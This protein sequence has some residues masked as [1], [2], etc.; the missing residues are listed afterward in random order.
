[1]PSSS[2]P[3]NK[4]KINYRR[5]KMKKRNHGANQTAVSIPIGKQK[6]L[7]SIALLTFSLFLLTFSLSCEQDPSDTGNSNSNE[8]KVSDPH[9]GDKLSVSPAGLGVSFNMRYVPPTGDE[10]FQWEDGTDNIATIS[11]GYWIGE[12][13][14][15]QELFEAVMGH[16]PSFVQHDAAVLDGG[17]LS[18]LFPVETV[19]WYGAITFCNK[20]SILEGR[21]PVYS[22]EGYN[23]TKWKIMTY[24]KIPTVSDE[25][26]NAAAH[27]ADAN[28]YRLPTEMEWLWA[29]MGA[30]TGGEEVRATGWEKAFAGADGSRLVTSFAWQSINAGER[31]H[32]TGLKLANELGLF[33]MS[34]NVSE[35]CQ[36]W[37]AALP[38]G[39]LTDYEGP[40]T[41]TAKVTKGTNCFSQGATKLSTR[42]TSSPYL[43]GQ[44]TGLR[45][46][47]ISN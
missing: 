37:N 8:Q 14:V 39:A 9:T 24:D 34:G 41:G 3:I 4:I 19:S 1:L 7:R 43:R 33:D 11:E 40:G 44:T 38:A 35:W 10:G 16:N 18:A 36:D 22:V 13:E 46:V 21:T 15:T 28:G 26:W 29:A 31:T 25:A 2:S 42:S 20:L 5:N 32:Q 30:E 27:D 17:E 45:V 12:T 6:I 47:R 23:N